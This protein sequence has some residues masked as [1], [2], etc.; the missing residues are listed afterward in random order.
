MRR[1][2]PRRRRLLAAGS[3][4]TLVC[5]FAASVTSVAAAPKGTAATPAA[6]STPIYLNTSYP[7]QARAAD[8]VSRMTLAEKAAQLNTTSAQTRRGNPDLVD[9]FTSVPPST[10][11]RASSSRPAR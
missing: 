8:L 11:P 6:S 2:T 5:A 1:T 7:F 3:A 9:D 4:L 10:T